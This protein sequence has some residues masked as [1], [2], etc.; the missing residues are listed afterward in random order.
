MTRTTLRPWWAA[1]L[2]LALVA[3]AAPAVAQEPWADL[4]GDPGLLRMHDARMSFT[5]TPLR[6]G[7]VLIAGGHDGSVFHRSAEVFD[8]QSQRF[9]Q[10]GDMATPRYGHRATTLPD[11]RVLITGGAEAGIPR[12]STSVEVYDPGTEAFSPLGQLRQGRFGHTATLLADGKVLITGGLRSGQKLRFKKSAEVFDPATGGSKAVGPMRTGRMM[13]V[14]VPLDRGRMAIIGGFGAGRAGVRAVEVYVPAR[15]RFQPRPDLVVPVDQP[16]AARLGDG[17]VLVI[18]ASGRSGILAPDARSS[19][20][21]RLPSRQG[22][23]TTTP[24]DDGRV[25]I[26][27]SGVGSGPPAVEIFDS[28]TDGVKRAGSLLTDRA[29]HVAARLDDDTVLVVGGLRSGSDCYEVLDSA[30]IWDPRAMSTVAAA[31]ETECEPY[32]APTPAPLPPLGAE[33]A[34]GRI[35]MPA[36]AFAITVPDDWSVELAD[37]DT[38][39]FRAEAGTAWEALRATSPDG[40]RACSV[41]VG[42]ADVSLRQGAGTGA[43]GVASPAWHPSKKGMLMVPSPRVKE[44]T[45]ETSSM[46]SVE[47]LHRDHAGL[48]H[49]ALYSLVCANVPGGRFEQIMFSLE[50]LPAAE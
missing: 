41:A 44:S 29:D 28:A 48:E 43:N 27:T 37:P 16:A 14:A 8:P 17:R 49:D 34:G 26:I 15:Q 3:S 23:A 13:H 30:E 4:E 21:L 2:T 6:D 36:S 45:R 5:A 35:E 20:P 38:D 50:L 31:A 32:V 33:T 22:K 12:G 19:E 9:R 46:T 11:G 7:K 47:R 10:V 24:L 18:S 1:A 25:I 40:E 42:V 39:V